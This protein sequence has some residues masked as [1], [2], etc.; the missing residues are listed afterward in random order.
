MSHSICACH[1]WANIST[2]EEGPSLLYTTHDF[3]PV[4]AVLTC[5]R[6]HCVR[7]VST[8]SCAFV[9]ACAVLLMGGAKHSWLGDPGFSVLVV[10]KHM[11]QV[12]AGCLA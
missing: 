9:Y 7:A 8:C 1:M 12:I 4:P 11:Q 2:D 5:S 3:A 6:A 10:Q